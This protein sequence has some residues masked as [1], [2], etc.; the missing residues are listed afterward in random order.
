MANACK[1]DKSSIVKEG[2]QQ[3]E[4][5]L[6]IPKWKKIGLPFTLMLHNYTNDTNA[7][8]RV[9]IWSNYLESPEY[10]EDICIKLKDFERHSN[11][12]VK[13]KVIPNWRNVWY[14]VLA[15][16]Y[17]VET[18]ENPETTFNLY[19]EYWTE[20]AEEILRGQLLELKNADK[21]NLLQL[22]NLK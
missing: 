8:I 16:D 5:K 11:G 22:D 10:K 12:L 6:I 4:L 21:E 14:S 15:S 7:A 3:N 9:F 20:E 13:Y 1:I 18:W 19:S 17:D 2:N